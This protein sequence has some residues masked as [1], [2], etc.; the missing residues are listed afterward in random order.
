MKYLLT[1]IQ[2]KR[3]FAFI[4]G[5]MNSNNPMLVFLHNHKLNLLLL[6]FIGL[7]GELPD[8][9]KDN[10]VLMGYLTSH[11]TKRTLEISETQPLGGQ[12]KAQYLYVPDNAIIVHNNDIEPT[13]NPDNQDILNKYAVKHSKDILFALKDITLARPHSTAFFDT[14]EGI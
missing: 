10:Q 9:D 14:R 3:L 2:S 5:F 12:N 13:P 6:N 4:Q 7:F 11:Y 8:E 1:L